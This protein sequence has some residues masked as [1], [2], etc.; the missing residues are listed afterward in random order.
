MSEN[1]KNIFSVNNIYMDYSTQNNNIY[2]RPV[3]GS[4]NRDFVNLYR[5]NTNITLPNNFPYIYN[6]V[7]N[8]FVLRN[9]I[10]DNRFTTPT[11]R[12]KFQNLEI[13]NDRLVRRGT[14]QRRRAA[15][16]I[17]DRLRFLNQRQVY[18]NNVLVDLYSLRTTKNG[19]QY[20]YND[21]TKNV[22]FTTKSQYR[23]SN[24]IFLI[25]REGS[26]NKNKAKELIRNDFPGIQIYEYGVGQG[27]FTLTPND[28]I[29]NNQIA[30]IDNI[31]NI[32]RAGYTIYHIRKVSSKPVNRNTLDLKKVKMYHAKFGIESE[33]ISKNFTDK[34]NMSCVPEALWYKYCNPETNKRPL[35]LSLEEIANELIDPLD[36]DLDSIQQGFDTEEIERFCKKHHIPMY[37]LDINEKIFHTYYPEKRSHH[38][39]TLAFIVANDH[40][41]LCEGQSFLNFLNS[42]TR[43][44]VSS[45]SIKSKKD[46]EEKNEIKNTDVIIHKNHLEDEFIDYFK[47]T[48]KIISPKNMLV[49]NGLIKKMII[50]KTTYYANSNELLIK[51][52]IK[53]YN[54]DY[55]PENELKFTNQTPSSFGRMLFNKLYPKHKQSKLNPQV[56]NLHYIF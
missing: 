23:L 9:N 46:S 7:T 3:I 14:I 22:I 55:K 28:N 21:E 13:D 10:F 16:F 42:T 15:T 29:T 27:F 54:E 6:S 45:S 40:F 49:I 5:Q 51:K 8:R 53:K 31:L 35:K 25:N 11:L 30:T 19:R 12:R 33:N 41:Y 34:G 26:L 1:S 4:S 36:S 39:S 38:L 50:D 2:Y 18:S 20:L 32:D 37:A 48:N 44:N 43:E 17:Q 47:K 24:P 56:Y 52:Y